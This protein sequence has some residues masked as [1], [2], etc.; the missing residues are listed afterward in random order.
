MTNFKGISKIKKE[1]ESEIRLETDLVNQ[2]K[3]AISGLFRTVSFEMDNQKNKNSFYCFDTISNFSNLI[4]KEYQSNPA[5]KAIKEI[6]LFNRMVIDLLKDIV[7]FFIALDGY[8]SHK[9]KTREL[10][11]LSKSNIEDGFKNLRQFDLKIKGVFSTKD[12]PIA[13]K[14]YCLK[15]TKESLYLLNNNIYI[16]I[17]KCPFQSDF[18]KLIQ[19]LEHSISNLNDESNFIDFTKT[20]NEPKAVK[21][22]E[23]WYALLYWFELKVSGKEPPK[24]VDGTFIKSEL[25]KIGAIKCNSTGL[26]FYNSF[27][28]IDI[29][30]SKFLSKMFGNTWQEHVKKLSNNNLEIIKHIDENY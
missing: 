12:S 7:Q 13:M 20:L 26:S 18:N 24:G 6:E 8:D 17:E 2:Y 21:I 30:N 16:D 27:K 22:P 23:K 3:Q 15:V 9:N 11:I 1:K 25:K 29:N 4:T 5:L 10:I 28:E 19:K 14:D